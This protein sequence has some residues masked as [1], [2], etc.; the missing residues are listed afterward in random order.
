MRMKSLNRM[1]RYCENRLE[2]SDL[3]FTTWFAACLVS[4]KHAQRVRVFDSP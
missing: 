3:G 1:N 2:N 4:A